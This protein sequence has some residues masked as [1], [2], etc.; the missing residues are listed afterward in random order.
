MSGRIFHCACSLLFGVALLGSRLCTSR[1]VVGVLRVTGIAGSRE[2]AVCLAARCL[3]V[4]HVF[5]LHHLLLLRVALAIRGL[6]A[7][8][9][10]LLVVDLAAAV[11]QVVWVDHR[12]HLRE[13][14]SD[15]RKSLCGVSEWQLAPGHELNALSVHIHQVL[16]ARGARQAS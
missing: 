14:L 3:N 10:L 6:A 13:A 4:R 16:L 9:L 12:Q 8:H 5:A 15:T 1:T 7:V 11:R 2:L